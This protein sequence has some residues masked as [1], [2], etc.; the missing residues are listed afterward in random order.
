MGLLEEK[1]QNL[2]ERIAT[3]N[4]IKEGEDIVKRS[5][6]DLHRDGE[7]GQRDHRVVHFPNEP[8][9]SATART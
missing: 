8:S 4:E 2:E 9:F 3:L 5:H 1:F 7:L 6:E